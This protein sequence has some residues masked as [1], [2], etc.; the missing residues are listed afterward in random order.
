MLNHPKNFSASLERNRLRPGWER[1][2]ACY[3]SRQ[4]AERRFSVNCY[5]V[6]NNDHA[7]RFTSMSSSV[8]TAAR[9]EN[10]LAISV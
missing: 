1:Y 8:R 9:P 7:L 3:V 10:D 4:L 6:L 5:T 2:L